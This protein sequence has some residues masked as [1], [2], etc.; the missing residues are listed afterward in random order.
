MISTPP[1]RS[2]AACCQ[3]AT[4]IV[5]TSYPGKLACS[6]SATRQ[7]TSSHPREREQRKESHLS[8]RS[9]NHGGISSTQNPDSVVRGTGRC[10]GATVAC[11]LCLALPYLS[12]SLAKPRPSVLWACD[13]LP[14]FVQS[15][16]RMPTHYS[17]SPQPF[18]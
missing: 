1:F 9:S 8:H 17:K 5:W 11:T 18:I 12:L 7:Q 15:A 2:P 6:F 13:S 16:T 3:S 14:V 10:K 4:N